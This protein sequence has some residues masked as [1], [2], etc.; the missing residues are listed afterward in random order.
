MKQITRR[1]F[2]FG[3]AA[4]S[5]VGGVGFRRLRVEGGAVAD[6]DA[7]LG[8]EQGDLCVLVLGEDRGVDAAWSGC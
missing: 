7:D 3:S 6:W 8:I 1:G 5:V 4:L 2:V